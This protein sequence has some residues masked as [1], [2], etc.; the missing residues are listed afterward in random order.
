MLLKA[1]EEM[2]YI[3][4]RFK[5]VAREDRTAGKPW[6]GHKFRR[7]DQTVHEL[8]CWICGKWFNYSTLDVDVLVAA[9]R[10]DF[11]KRQPKHCGNSHCEEWNRRHEIHLVKTK[12]E[13]DEYYAGMFAK[14]KRKGLVA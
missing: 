12:Q 10:W 4:D 2:T 7:S 14:L 3:G 11:R 8:R 5:K 13:K 9:G 1:E 6:L